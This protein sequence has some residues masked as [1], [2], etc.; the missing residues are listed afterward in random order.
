M[1]SRIVSISVWS[2]CMC[3]HMDQTLLKPQ[4]YS[5]KA[6][7]RSLHMYMLV[8]TFHLTVSCCQIIV[9]LVG[10]DWNEDCDWMGLSVIHVLS[11]IVLLWCWHQRHCCCFSFDCAFL[12]FVVIGWFLSFV[13][14]RAT[15]ITNGF[16]RII[17][18]NFCDKL[19]SMATVSFTL[20][21][22]PLSPKEPPTEVLSLHNIHCVNI[23]KRVCSRHCEIFV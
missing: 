17:K 15:Y 22:M 10:M 18:P 12:G 19:I 21:P 9:G 23:F 13:I 4:G 3:L 11:F 20:F 6:I 14:P 2:F 7:K 5:S 8:L 16:R 1:D